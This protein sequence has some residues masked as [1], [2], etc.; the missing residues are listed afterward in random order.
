MT[1]LSTCERCD[2]P[3]VPVEYVDHADEWWCANC[4]ENEAERAWERHQDDLMENGPGST[5]LEQQ[6]EA[7]KLK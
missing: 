3:K 4:I 5:L 7:R 6:A 1:I 2:K